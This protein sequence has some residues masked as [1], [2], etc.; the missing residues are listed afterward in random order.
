[1]HINAAFTSLLFTMAAAAAG[2]EGIIVVDLSQEDLERSTCLNN[3]PGADQV[4][5]VAAANPTVRTA[6]VLERGEIVA[7]YVRDGLNATAPFHVWSTTKSYMGLL[8]G[9]LVE[10][11]ELLLDETLLDVWPDDTTIWSNVMAE[12]VDFRKNVTI[13]SLLTMT[14]GLVVNSPDEWGDTSDGGD[15]GGAT[16]VGSLA[17][18]DIGEKGTF[19]YLAVS[20]ILSYVIKERTGMSSS[21]YAARYVWPSLG[22]DDSETGWWKNQDGMDYAFHG[23][24]LTAAQM[25]KF[26]QLYLQE[27]LAGPGN[28]LISSEWVSNSSY[29]QVNATVEAP[30]APTWYPNYG[31]L[32]WVL[33]GMNLGIS[34][35]GDFYCALGLGGQDI[36][37]SPEL[38]RV[39]V[40]QRDVDEEDGGLVIATV[41]FNSDLS[42][43][44]DSVENSDGTIVCSSA[45]KW[46]HPTVTSIIA[47]LTLSMVVF[48]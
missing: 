47:V 29:P 1:M 21:E 11:D 26:G 13:R 5:E 24:Q 31:Y 40:Q 37:V 43:V 41:A 19:S 45:V 17:F 14:S 36:C 9:L 12:D 42:F 16:L 22:I 44:G 34:N 27:G 23:A 18:P 38:Q 8:V 15:A 6:L 33:S 28:A 30:D 35:V 10:S 48:F 3:N 4:A 39:S 46:L 2:Q 20:N 7:D 32:F 25:A